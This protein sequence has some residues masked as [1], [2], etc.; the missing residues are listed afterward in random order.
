MA[1]APVSAG[2]SAS[3]EQSEKDTNAFSPRYVG[4]SAELTNKDRT[5]KIASTSKSIRRTI[6][7]KGQNVDNFLSERSSTRIHQP[8]GGRSTAGS[9]MSVGVGSGHVGSA[10][11]AP[12]RVGAWGRD[13]EHVE[14]FATCE[15]G[16]ATAVHHHKD[17]TSSFFFSFF[18]SSPTHYPFFPTQPPTATASVGEPMLRPPRSL[19]TSL[20]LGPTRTPAT[21]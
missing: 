20:P 9:L 11:G 14:C 4:H 3:P 5:V 15:E 21:S 2:N 8:S 6:M 18:F 1:P 19:P 16:G 12:H 13:Q 17:C 7:S 10:M